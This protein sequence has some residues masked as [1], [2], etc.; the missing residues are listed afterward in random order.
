MITESL[1]NAIAYSWVLGWYA[2]RDG[3]TNDSGKI[4]ATKDI[5][6]KHPD[7]VTACNSHADLLEACKVLVGSHRI[8]GPC[9]EN[10]CTSC[11]TA[12]SHGLDAIAKAEPTN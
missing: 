10:G 2:G 7:I 12:Y 3:V 4:Q 1:D 5:K 8:H 9:R 11:L 6:E